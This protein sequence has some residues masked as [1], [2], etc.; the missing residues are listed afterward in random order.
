MTDRA[1]D[2][3]CTLLY[4]DKSG[5]VIIN[6]EEI[7]QATSKSTGG[8]MTRISGYSEYRL[9]AYDLATGKLLARVELGEGQ[10]DGECRIIGLV[11]DKLWMFSMNPELGFH[12]RNP[13]TLETEKTQ[14]AITAAAPFN[15]FKFA[16]PDWPQIGQFYGMSADQKYII[17]TDLSGFRFKYDPIT[18]TITKTTDD[19]ISCDLWSSPP[20]PLSNSIQINSDS[21][22]SLN[23]EPRKMLQF[24]Y[25][26]GKFDA[27]Y[28]KGEFMVTGNQQKLA[29][30]FSNELHVIVTT[31]DSLT[32]K[33]KEL[34]QQFPVLAQSNG[35]SSGMN[36]SERKAYYKISDLKRD[37]A[38]CNYDIR[39][40]SSNGLRSVNNKSITGNTTALIFHCKDVTDTSRCMISSLSLFAGNNARENW[41]VMLNRYYFNPDKAD[42]LG[43]FETVM[44]EGDP[45]FRYRWFDTHD[46]KLIMISQLQ[47]CAIDLSTGKIIWDIDL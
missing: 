22:V 46:G 45:E 14:A 21:T 16:V 28:L 41:S 7:F 24:D 10:K 26:P 3:M 2:I 1:D 32:R 44:S 6:R 37:T 5:T 29:A 43:A 39:S 19:L 35:R 4:T 40:I 17:V 27:S 47:M 38:E 36:D 34:Q 13:R 8:G 30:L 20:A 33:I 18:Q 31:K 25:K 15:N 9:S 12:Y 23:G 11:N 42:A